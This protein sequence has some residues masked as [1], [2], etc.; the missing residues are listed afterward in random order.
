M[1]TLVKETGSAQNPAAN[2]YADMDD[3]AGY[4]GTRLNIDVWNNATG[5]NQLIALIMA[6][7]T[8][9]AMFQ[10]NGEKVSQAQPLQWPRIYCLDPDNQ[11]GII[12]TATR[13]S[14]RYFPSDKVPKLV[15]N[16][17][18]ELA[19]QLLTSD[20]TNDPQGTGISRIKIDEVMDV[21]FAKGDKMP[22]VPSL[23]QSWLS[24]FAVYLGGA[25]GAVRLVR[26]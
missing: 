16:S 10:F 8:I 21:T 15:I 24:K 13:Y 11:Q 2:S 25:S 7:R 22:V 1:P 12:P 18:C 17:T 20:R 3:A 9:D 23:V 6:T 14:G 26:T 19:M 4:F 5:D